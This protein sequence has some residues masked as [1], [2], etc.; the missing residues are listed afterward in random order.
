MPSVTIQLF[1]VGQGDGILTQFPDGTTMLVDLGTVKNKKV[2]VPSINS[3]VTAHTK[4]RKAGQTLDYLVLSHG[5]RDHYNLVKDFLTGFQI[6]VANLLYGGQEADYRGLVG[7][8]RATY[9]GLNELGSPARYPHPLGRFGGAEVWIVGMNAA[10]IKKRNDEGWR[11]NTASV[12]LQIRYGDN[13]VMLTGDATTDTEGTILTHFG[14]D[15]KLAGGL[16]STV[17]K[18]QHHGSARTSFRP[19]WIAEVQPEYVFISSDRSGSRGDGIRQT[20]Y[21]LPQELALD[22]IRK[23][24]KLATGAK[25]P[26]VSLFSERDYSGWVNPD[27]SSKRGWP[28]KHTGMGW[29]PWTTEE[30]IFTSLSAMDV[31]S[32]DGSV[33]DQGVQYEIELVSDGSLNVRSTE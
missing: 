12:V 25:H 16:R 22:I 32:A 2:T 9:P 33:A 28:T 13:R 7:W 21:G 30:A 23:H 1:D 24:S 27:D 5:D 18:A 4:F 19:S 20:G 29:V 26:Y 8:L 17:L 10:A 31:K 6:K 14:A 11:K 15:P 3:Y